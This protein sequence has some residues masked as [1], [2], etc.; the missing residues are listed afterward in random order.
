MKEG[1]GEIQI[2]FN[3]DLPPGPKSRK[4]IFIN[5]HESRMAAYLVN[6]LLPRDRSVR[7]LAQNRNRNQSFYE[8]DYVQSGSQPDAAFTSAPSIIRPFIDNLGGL[9]SMF[10]LGM[11]HIAEGTDH[12]LFL[13]ALLLPSPLLTFRSN[14]AAFAG[15]RQSVTRILGIVTAFTVGH[16]ITLALAGL[17][18]VVVPSRPIEILIAVSILVSAIHAFRPLFFGRETALAAFF[19]LIHGLAFAATLDHLGLGFWA[20]I[21]NLFAFNIG[22]EAMQLT[23]VLATMPSLVLLSRTRAYS[24]LRVGGALFAG[25]TSTGWVVERIL[26][27]HSSVDALIDPIAHRAPWIAALLFVV[28]VLCWSIGKL[29]SKQTG[30]PLRGRPLEQSA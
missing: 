28:S 11:R 21:G 8:L 9:G 26:N 4:L 22:I 25:L 29:A 14:W 1:L 19:G 6:C 5:H 10:R 12:L 20:R 24:F 3:A 18:F 13:L 15:L 23:V 17:G 2:Y 27:L 16:S 7:I 30:E